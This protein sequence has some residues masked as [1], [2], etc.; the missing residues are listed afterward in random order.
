MGKVTAGESG[1][2]GTPAFCFCR[3][4]GVAKSSLKLA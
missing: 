1:P 2:G 4:A 3:D